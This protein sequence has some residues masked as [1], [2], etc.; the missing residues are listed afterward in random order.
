[1]NQLTLKKW[2]KYSK[3][4]F[5]NKLLPIVIFFHEMYLYIFEL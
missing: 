3:F 2:Y 4:Y 1:M 5:V